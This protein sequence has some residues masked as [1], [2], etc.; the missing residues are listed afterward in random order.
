ML[1]F[2]YIVKAGVV[3][4]WVMNCSVLERAARRDK[5]KRNESHSELREVTAKN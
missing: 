3:E 4:H 2:I 1:Y 5:E